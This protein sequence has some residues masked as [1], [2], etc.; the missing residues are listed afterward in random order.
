MAATHVHTDHHHY[1]KMIMMKGVPTK[2]GEL[3]EQLGHL[4]GVLHAA[5]SLSSTGKRLH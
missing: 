5:L 2:L 4:K 3:A 1:A